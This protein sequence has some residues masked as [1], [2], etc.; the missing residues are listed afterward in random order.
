VSEAAY[1]D[2]VGVIN[3]G[4]MIIVDTPSQ[5]RYLAYGG[6]LVS[7]KTGKPLD[8]ETLLAVSELPFVLNKAQ[9]IDDFSAQV[10]VVEARHDIAALLD[11]AR[12]RSLKIVAIEES[13]PSFDDVF[14]ELVNKAGVEDE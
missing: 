6:E 7:F 11:W 5:L 2:L 14:V 4:E 8:H 3:E 1:C 12:K 13:L 9:R 10:L